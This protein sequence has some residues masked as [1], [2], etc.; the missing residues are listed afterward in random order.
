MEQ[1]L[2][3]STGWALLYEIVQIRNILDAFG[4]WTIC[5]YI[6]RYLGDV[7]PSLNTKLTCGSWIPDLHIPNAILYCVFFF[8]QFFLWNWCQNVPDFGVFGVWDF[9]IWNAQSI[10]LKNLFLPKVPENTLNLWL[11]WIS[12]APSECISY[13]LLIMSH[14]TAF[15][16]EE[17][18]G[19]RHLCSRCHG[20]YS[21]GEESELLRSPSVTSTHHQ[22]GVLSQDGTL[23]M[24]SLSQCFLPSPQ[25]QLWP[26]PSSRED[27][28]IWTQAHCMLDGPVFPR[29][30]CT[31]F[32][33]HLQ[34][35]IQMGEGEEKAEQRSWRSVCCHRCEMTWVNS[36]KWN[37]HGFPG[38]K[39]P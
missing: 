30:P 19:E 1:Q 21:T 10:Y 28:W 6:I 7:T 32:R 20:I 37:K 33:P 38:W 14:L 12:P 3:G 27:Q 4:Y 26:G 31:T 24:P 25:R 5:M 23:P 35:S 13:Q 22:P 34:K 36:L 18:W 9:W 15:L 39:S 2:I 17:P 16:L 11:H 8:N 29:V